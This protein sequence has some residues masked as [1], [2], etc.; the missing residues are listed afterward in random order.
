MDGVLHSDGISGP[1]T[2]SISHA[3]S[4]LCPL[5]GCVR[6]FSLEGQTK[7]EIVKIEEKGGRRSRDGGIVDGLR[8]S[9]EIEHRFDS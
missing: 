1:L 3:P 8:K 2:L 9:D 6:D 5:I 4:L 7:Q